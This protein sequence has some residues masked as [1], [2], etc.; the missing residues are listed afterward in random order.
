MKNIFNLL[1]LGILSLVLVSCGDD[2]NPPVITINSP[3]PNS[4]LGL[5]SIL[6]LDVTVMDDSEV[7]TLTLVSETA[8]AGLD[9]NFDLST[10]DD[11]TI[12]QIG[13]EIDLESIPSG[14]YT[15]VLTATD[16]QGD[17]TSEDINFTIQ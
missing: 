3:A 13:V 5:D 8:A 16:D 4:I 6:S 7:S 12:V 9:E 1:L 17:S 2:N 15:F 14:D 10:F 11:R